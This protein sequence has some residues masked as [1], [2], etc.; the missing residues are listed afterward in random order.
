LPVHDP[1]CSLGKQWVK[2]YS[3]YEPGENIIHKDIDGDQG[4]F[5]RIPYECIKEGTYRLASSID[6]GYYTICLAKDGAWHHYT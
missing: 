4:G 1:I 6:T 5:V 2:K 3:I